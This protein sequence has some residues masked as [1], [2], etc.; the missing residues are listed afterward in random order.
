MLVN[1]NHLLHLLYLCAASISM[2]IVGLLKPSN[3]RT[4]MITLAVL[5]QMSSIFSIRYAPQY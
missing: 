1:P 4:K 2:L 5:E 3:A